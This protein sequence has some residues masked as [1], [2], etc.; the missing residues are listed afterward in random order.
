MCTDAILMYGI[1]HVI[2]AENGEDCLSPEEE[3]LRF[4]N[5]KVT[6]MHDAE[7]KRKSQRWI[8]KHPAVWYEDV[9]EM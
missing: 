9:A 6:V 1:P 7:C 5:V 3:L 4:Y 2:I 8:E